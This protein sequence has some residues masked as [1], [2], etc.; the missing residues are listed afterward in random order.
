MEVIQ[1]FL[2]MPM[3]FDQVSEQGWEYRIG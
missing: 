2:P 1:R 3:T